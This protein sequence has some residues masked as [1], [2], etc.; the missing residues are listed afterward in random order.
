MEWAKSQTSELRFSPK[1]TNLTKIISEIIILNQ[2]SA[3]AKNI[4]LQFSSA[5]QIELYT[6]ENMVKTVLR[7]LIAN[8]IKF[9]N[10]GGII[11]ILVN[12]T[13]EQAEIAIIDNGIGMS[14]KAIRE[15]F[16]TNTSITSTGTANEKGSGLGLILCKQ[17]VKKL[18]G[19]LLV[20]S[21]IGKGSTFKLIL[22][23]S[24]STN[25]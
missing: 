2:S 17:L 4:A 3:Q 25:N 13:K 6:D 23:L 9:T 16:D 20:E 15:I 12:I 7:N 18:N 19:N 5:Q 8:A 11:K 22:P 21:E 14:K 1:K 24:T 10:F